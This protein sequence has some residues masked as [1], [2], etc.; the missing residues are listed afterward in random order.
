MLFRQ[1]NKKNPGH[2]GNYF[3]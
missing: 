3:F 2:G 1:L